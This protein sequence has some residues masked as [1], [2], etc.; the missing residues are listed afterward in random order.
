M[1]NMASFNYYVDRFVNYQSA[2]KDNDKFY[3]KI[4]I[5]EIMAND[6]GVSENL[7]GAVGE[8]LGFEGN[9]I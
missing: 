6:L 1:R 3:F 8:N 7:H 5:Y 4:N 2:S 9:L